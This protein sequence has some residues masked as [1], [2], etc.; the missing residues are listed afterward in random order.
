MDKISLT[1]LRLRFFGPTL[2]ESVFYGIDCLLD[3]FGTKYNRFSEEEFKLAAAERS[4]T[5]KAV[6]DLNLYKSCHDVSI[7]ASSSGT[8]PP[9]HET[10]SSPKTSSSVRSFEKDTLNKVENSMLSSSDGVSSP[11]ISGTSRDKIINSKDSSRRSSKEEKMLTLNDSRKS[12]KESSILHTANGGSNPVQESRRSSE[13]FRLAKMQVDP[14]NSSGEKIGSEV[15]KDRIMISKEKVIDSKNSSRRSSNDE[16]MSIKKRIQTSPPFS[17]EAFKPFRSPK[18]STTAGNNSRTNSFSNSKVLDKIKKELVNNSIA[19]MKIS[20]SVAG[21]TV[22]NSPPRKR[23]L[24]SSSNNRYN[25]PS[26][27]PAQRPKQILSRWA[28]ARVNEF[29][30]G[31][32]TYDIV[33]DETLEQKLPKLLSECPVPEIVFATLPD[34]CTISYRF[35]KEKSKC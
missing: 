22:P 23:T 1:D 6:S 8:A 29:D 13:S 3:F 18:L 10:L 15:S 30:D 5:K 34:G 12:S 25:T 16:K 21:S 11:R 2:D 17:K 20:P 19:N 9:S 32:K 14:T 24:S 4:G 33:L 28:L 7:N 26:K 31:A 35:E 27:L